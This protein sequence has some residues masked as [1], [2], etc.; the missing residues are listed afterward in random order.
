MTNRGGAMRFRCAAGREH[1]HGWVQ[2]MNVVLAALLY[3]TLLLFKLINSCFS[4]SF[5]FIYLFICFAGSAYFS[6]IKYCVN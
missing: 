1:S 4:F 3:F 6:R 5:L 2:I